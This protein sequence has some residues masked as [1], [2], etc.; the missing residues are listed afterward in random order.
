MKAVRVPTG[1]PG[2][3]ELIDGGFPARRTV[4]L[5]GG[6]GSGKTILAIQFLVYG[7]VAS[8]D[9]VL[10]VSLEEKKEDLYREMLQFGWDLT[11]LEAERKFFFFDATQLLRASPA[12]PGR[13]PWFGRSETPH[14][15]LELIESQIKQV[16]PSRIVIDPISSIAFELP[17]LVDRREALLKLMNVLGASGANSILNAELRPAGMSH[18]VQME[19]HLAHGVVVLDSPKKG[20]RSLFVEKMRETTIDLNPRPYQIG[21]KGIVVFPKQ[22]II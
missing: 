13:L 20:P 21:Q 2:L 18:D 9:R 6:P 11:K 7:T 22:S 3:D 15:L 4:L 12:Q 14:S 5:V 10:Y 16:R 1:V 17:D 19:E 8:D